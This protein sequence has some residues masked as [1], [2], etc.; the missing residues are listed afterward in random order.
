MAGFY[1]D[2][3]G[4]ISRSAPANQCYLQVQ[5]CKA[6]GDSLDSYESNFFYSG[7]LA[8]VYCPYRAVSSGEYFVVIYRAEEIGREKGKSNANFIEKICV[9]SNKFSIT[10]TG[11]AGVGFSFANNY[12]IMTLQYE[13]ASKDSYKSFTS[14]KYPQDF[15]GQ[16]AKCSELQLTNINTEKYGWIGAKVTI[17]IVQLNKNNFSSISS[18]NFSDSTSQSYYTNYILANSKIEGSFY[19]IQPQGYKW[20]FI[21]SRYLSYGK[22]KRTYKSNGY[23]TVSPEYNDDNF[24]TYQE[25]ECFALVRPGSPSIASTRRPYFFLEVSAQEHFQ[26]KDTTSSLYINN[27]NITTTTANK[28][29]YQVPYFSGND[30]TSGYSDSTTSGLWNNSRVYPCT[31]AYSDDQFK[32]IVDLDIYPVECGFDKSSIITILNTDPVQTNNN[33]IR[34]TYQRISTKHKNADENK[35]YYND[36]W[37]ITLTRADE[38]WRNPK[39]YNSEKITIQSSQTSTT[40]SIYQIQLNGYDTTDNKSTISYSIEYNLFSLKF[41]TNFNKT[42][43]SNLTIKRK[44]TG[45]VWTENTGQNL[46]LGYGEELEIKFNIMYGYNFNLLNTINNDILYQ[47]ESSLQQNSYTKNYITTSNINFVINTITPIK[48][49]LQIQSYPQITTTVTQTYGAVARHEA[50]LTVDDPDYNIEYNITNSDNSFDSPVLYYGDQLSVQYTLDDGYSRNIAALNSYNFIDSDITIDPRPFPTEYKLTK[51]IKSTNITDAE[52]SD[53]TTYLHTQD[54]VITRT[55]S[56]IHQNDDDYN[57]YKNQ[58][59]T[60]GENGTAIYYHDVFSINEIQPNDGYKNVVLKTL[61][62]D[63]NIEDYQETELSINGSSKYTFTLNKADNIILEADATLKSWKLRFKD[64]SAPYHA[65]VKV[66]RVEKNQHMP[67]VKYGSDNPLEDLQTVYYFDK[68]EATPKAQSGYKLTRFVVPNESSSINETIYE[69]NNIPAKFIITELTDDWIAH[70]Q[71][72]ISQFLAFSAQAQA[73]GMVWIG[74]S[75]S[76]DNFTKKTRQFGQYAKTYYDDNE[77]IWQV[78]YNPTDF[79][80]KVGMFYIGSN[81]AADVTKKALICQNNIELIM[82]INGYEWCILSCAELDTNSI[83]YNNNNIPVKQ[84]IPNAI[85]HTGD[86]TNPFQPSILPVRIMMKELQHSYLF[87]TVKR[88]KDIDNTSVKNHTFFNIIP[89]SRYFVYGRVKNEQNNFVNTMLIPYVALPKLNNNEELGW[90][91]MS[92]QD[93]LMM[94]Q[95]NIRQGILNSYYNAA[96][97]DQDADKIALQLSIPASLS[98]PV[99]QSKTLTL[100]CIQSTGDNNLRSE[101]YIE[102]PTELNLNRV[103]AFEFNESILSLPFDPPQLLFKVTSDNGLLPGYYYFKIGDVP[104]SFYYDLFNGNEPAPIPK[105]GGFRYENRKLYIYGSDTITVLRT[106]PV[107]KNKAFGQYL[108][109]TF[110]DNS[111]NSIISNDANSGGEFNYYNLSLYG[112]NDFASSWLKQWFNSNEETFTFQQNDFH[113]N[114]PYQ[115]P[116]FLNLFNRNLDAVMGKIRLSDNTLTSATFDWPQGTNPSEYIPIQPTI[117]FI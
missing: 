39:I 84:S 108:G 11:T 41:D 32:L 79:N 73:N 97:D 8:L 94:R 69:G 35:C 21:T 67:D 4:N 68:L 60:P 49:N 102:N 14:D 3:N 56:P 5:T 40:E 10:A 76:S 13:N 34:T 25:D 88:S 82:D 104:Y 17:S 111:S 75:I 65:T 106:I 18:I 26:L 15:R 20:G 86:I 48:Y 70:S 113:R 89:F 44:K 52:T 31:N 61:V 98:A 16:Y 6:L 105:N 114:I 37:R 47:D 7:S 115:V 117:Y 77:H 30:I 51:I 19:H 33:S 112:S 38:I 116:G 62:W 9:W 23:V 74:D 110:A 81:A 64:E 46:I 45:D 63:E 27:V 2:G 83:E 28:Y 57:S 78:E 101:H 1:I 99:R 80:K 100:N 92:D 66:Y 58:T 55:D 42:Q 90:Y 85:C 22:V 54:F 50:N 87:I 109:Q 72:S 95:G 103:T 29:Q 107:D 93:S 71:G 43:I 36:I 91:V 53:V 59:I 24:S 96:H 12:N